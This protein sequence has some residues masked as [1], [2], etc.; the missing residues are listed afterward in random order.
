M[1]SSYFERGILE[2]FILLILL[3]MTFGLQQ[4][5]K[6]DMMFESETKQWND[7]FFLVLPAIV[8]IGYRLYFAIVD[9]IVNMLV[10]TWTTI[11]KL[12]SIFI[13]I[14]D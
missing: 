5:Y 13:Q 11:G 8:Y 3:S 6:F 2:I 7:T 12:D 4:V 1:T 14:H 10:K 9:Y